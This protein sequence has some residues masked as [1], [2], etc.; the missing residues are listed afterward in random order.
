MSIPS[1]SEIIFGDFDYV[2]TAAPTIGI[3]DAMAKAEIKGL[4]TGTGSALA[5]DAISVS[6]KDSGVDSSARELVKN[7]FGTMA[8]PKV[9]AKN[10][11]AKLQD[12]EKED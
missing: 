11:E 5:A 7:Q 3:S 9:A 2:S 6:A 12:T 8:D 4:E 1:Q 10:I